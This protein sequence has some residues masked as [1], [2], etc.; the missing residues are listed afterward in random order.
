LKQIVLCENDE[1]SI[2]STLMYFNEDNKRLLLNAMQRYD[3]RKKRTKSL[4]SSLKSGLNSSLSLGRE[5]LIL[6]ARILD[7]ARNA[8]S[9]SL[10]ITETQKSDEDNLRANDVIDVGTTSRVNS[11]LLADV[12]ASKDKVGILLIVTSDDDGTLVCEF[13]DLVLEGTSLVSVA[14]GSI[15]D[16]QTTIETLGGK[17]DIEGLAADSD[18]EVEAV[19]AVAEG[20]CTSTLVVKGRAEGRGT[21]TTCIIQ[22]SSYEMS[23]NRTRSP[24]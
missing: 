19:I 3:M 17:G 10:D 6:L 1:S 7:R 15:N 9:T 8:T 13:F 14:L 20:E 23:K 22:K 21:G 11:D 5:E 4:H 12:A 2:N 24:R 18:R 16:D